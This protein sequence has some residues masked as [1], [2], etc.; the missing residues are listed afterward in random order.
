MKKGFILLAIFFCSYGK[1]NEGD[2]HIA[3]Y[4]SLDPHSVSQ[5]FAFYELYP[6]TQEGKKAL[7]RG[8]TLLWK[9][10]K[11]SNTLIHPLSLPP[12]DI[13]GII[14]VVNRE[15]YLPKINLNATQLEILNKLSYHL[16]NRSLKGYQVWSLKEL[17]ALPT[18]EID[19]A[20][21]ILLH[22]Y[23]DPKDRLFIEQYEANLDLIALQIKARLSSNPM[24]EE[25]ISCI[26][27]F[28]FQEMHFRFPPH[29]LYAKDI[30]LYTF[31]PSVLDSRQGVCLGVSILYLSLAQ[32]LNLPL[33]IITPPGHIYVRY[34]DKDRIINIETT[35]RGIDLPTETYLGINTKDLQTH[36]LKEV[37]GHSLINQASTLLYKQDYKTALELYE[38]AYIYMPG[39]RK[40][41]MLMGLCNLFC[42][43]IVQ[44][45]ALL[46]EIA[47]KPFEDEIYP[48]T[49][50]Q[51]YLD[52]KVDIDALKIIFVPV[53]ETRDSILAK[54][55]Q[56]LQVTRRFPK[57]R[58]GWMDLA[59]TWLQLSRRAEALACLDK[60]HQLD[61]GNPVAE[62]YELILSLES[63]DY[64]KAWYHYQK[65]YQATVEK[66]YTPRMLREIQTHLMQLS[67]RQKNLD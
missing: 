3:L 9:E 38:T 45:R 1:A 49:L 4:S 21:A 41:K 17:Q 19:I 40:L 63:L 29:S 16:K 58:E 44:G 5:N 25:M 54:Q 51:D 26:N 56:L 28:I 20:R 14:S 7:E 43:K 18:D 6:D 62:Y 46:K 52:G 32:R 8:W 23:P 36:T 66:G 34:R 30:D 61:R 12:C 10:A 42:G 47:G 15:T 11:L 53:D 65:L 50:S 2:N 33:E 24:P 37:V 39:D 35:A 31:L 59:I 55:K 27:H 67:P 64:P 13:Q 48:F 22:Q 57:F 60:H